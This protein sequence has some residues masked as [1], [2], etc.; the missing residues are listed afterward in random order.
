VAPSVALVTA[1]YGDYDYL[2]PLPDSHGFSRA[3]CVTDN[4]E[5]TAPGWEMVYKPSGAPPILAG[6]YPKMKPFDFVTEDIAVWL[7]GSFIVHDR[8]WRDFCVE[9]LGDSDVVAWAHPEARDCLYQE[10]EYCQ[11][12]EKYREYDIRKQTAHYRADGMPEGFGLWACGGLVWRNTQAAKK[13][14]SLWLV[15]QSRWSVQDQISFPYLVWKQNI[16]LSTFPA[17]QFLNPYL[18]YVGHK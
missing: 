10:A 13:F 15:H 4:P 16:K 8:G 18:T 6:K 12:W 17:H 7:D 9:S 2:Q 1:I 11:D 5:L 3:I 14:G